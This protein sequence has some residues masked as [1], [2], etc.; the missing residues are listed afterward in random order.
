MLDA[1]PLCVLHRCQLAVDGKDSTA[2][3]D[4]IGLVRDAF[5]A[6]RNQAPWE[7]HAAVVLP[8]SLYLLISMGTEGEGVDRFRRLGETIARHSATPLKFHWPIHTWI[9]RDALERVAREYFSMPVV[10]GLC[11]RPQDWPLSSIH[12]DAEPWA[13]RQKAKKSGLS[14]RSLKVAKDS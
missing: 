4:Q 1:A 5:A 12:R 14:N 7:T 11:A 6:E 8:S 9:H 2:L 10:W 3:T 13:D